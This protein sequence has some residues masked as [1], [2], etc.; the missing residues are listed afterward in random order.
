MHSAYLTVIILAAA[1][2]LYA[3]ASDFRRPDWIL[4]NMKRLNIEER[5]LPALGVPKILGGIGLLAGLIMPQIGIAAAAGLVLFFV[6][7]IVTAMRARWHE[8]L[9]YPLVWLA[10]AVASLVLFLH[11][12]HR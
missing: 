4:A 7:A 5:W 8:H 11:A 3:G 9:P 2:N 6:A 1:A 12:T 10:L